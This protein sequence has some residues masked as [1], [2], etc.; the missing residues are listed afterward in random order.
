MIINLKYRKSIDLDIPEICVNSESI[1]IFREV[2]NRSRYSLSNDQYMWIV[3]EYCEYGSLKNAIRQGKFSKSSEPYDFTVSLSD[4]LPMA[5][6]IANGLSYLHSHNII[7]GDLK[8]DNV[9]LSKSSHQNVK[10]QYKI[11]D[12]GLSRILN[13]DCSTIVTST[14]FNY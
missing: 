10:Y 1:E 6:D 4:V 13:I 12:F 5:L 3:T 7:H 8:I 2:E 9:L 14:H 11:G